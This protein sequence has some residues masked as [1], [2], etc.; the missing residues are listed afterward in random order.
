MFGGAL[1]SGSLFHAIS[2]G[3]S[4]PSQEYWREKVLEIRQRMEDLEE[5]VLKRG[6]ERRVPPRPSAPFQT[7]SS[8]RARFGVWIVAVPYVL[9]A[10]GNP[11]VVFMFWI[12][13]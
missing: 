8:L 13:F 5:A 6:G 10:E 7:E 3:L 9:G 11:D 12:Y 2:Y 4:R 1:A